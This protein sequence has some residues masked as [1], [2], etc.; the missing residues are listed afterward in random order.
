[1]LYSNRNIDYINVNKNY[2]NVDICRTNAKKSGINLNT[3]YKN[4]NL[5]YR[6]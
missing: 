2:R 3:K 6:N 5:D 1:M 4:T